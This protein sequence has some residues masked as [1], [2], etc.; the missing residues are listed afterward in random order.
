MTAEYE[1]AELVIDRVIR[2]PWGVR[3]DGAINRNRGHALE[4]PR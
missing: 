4:S 1:A 3:L 2:S